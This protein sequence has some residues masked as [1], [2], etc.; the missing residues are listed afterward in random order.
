MSAF[1]HLFVGIKEPRMVLTML[2]GKHTLV[3]DG[4]L[5]IGHNIINIL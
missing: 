1:Y 4:L 5:A 2:G 3:V